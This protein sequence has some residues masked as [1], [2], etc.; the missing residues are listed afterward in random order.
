M[1]DRFLTY[2]AAEVA[3]APLTVK[4]YS[5]DLHQW[6]RYMDTL[7]GPGAWSPLTATPR[8]IRA[9]LAHL[10]AKGT[11]PRTLQRKASSI[12]AL[13]RYLRLTGQI[14]QSPADLIPRAKTP[15]TLPVFIRTEEINAILNSSTPDADPD[16][17]PMPHLILLMLYT[18]GMRSA[19][20]I[21]LRDA[22]VDTASLQLKVRGKR[23]KDRIIPFGPELAHHITSYRHWRDSRHGT[24][25]DPQAPFFILPS[26]RPLYQRALYRIV[27]SQL[28]LAGAH[29]DRLSPHTLRHSCATDLLNN[30]AD[31][32][33]VSTLLGHASLASTQI[34]THISYRELK[35]NY[36]TAH[37]RAQNR[38][39][40]HHG[41]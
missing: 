1:I 15:K 20:I 24:N 39:D 2:L 35:S 32:N 13:Y 25:P 29:A 6:A 3:L 40:P 26:G 34:Y 23:G 4:A 36:L 22:A 10:A 33:A 38:K 21:S 16:A 31:L 28:S 41:S 8:Q 9:W 30:G 14:S 11:S 37:P 27:N 7:C 18:T 17:D 12:K 19:E 5:L